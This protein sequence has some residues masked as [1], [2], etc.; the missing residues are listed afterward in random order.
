MIVAVLDYPHRRPPTRQGAR[1][2]ATVASAVSAPEARK[3]VAAPPPAP[4]PKVPTAE[5]V[6][7]Y[8]E[9]SMTWAELV[10]PDRVYG[11]PLTDMT[12][13]GYTVNEAWLERAGHPSQAVHPNERQRRALRRLLAINRILDI[14]NGVNRSE[15][16]R[17]GVSVPTNEQLLA[18]F[19]NPSQSPDPFWR[20]L[21]TGQNEKWHI[22][23]KLVDLL[24]AN[25]GRILQHAQAADRYKA[26]GGTFQGYSGSLAGYAESFSQG[27][28]RSDD[29]RRD[30]FGACV[31]ESALY[32]T[33]INEPT[34]GESRGVQPGLSNPIAD[35]PPRGSFQRSSV[36]QD[37][38]T[39]Q[40]YADPGYTPPRGSL[41]TADPRTG[42]RGS[43]QPFD[44][45]EDPRGSWQPFDPGA[46]PRGSLQTADPRTGPTGSLQTA[47]PASGSTSFQTSST[48]S[49][50]QG[51]A[52]T[53]AMT[54]A[55]ATHYATPTSSNVSG[56]GGELGFSL[57][58][59]TRPIERIVKDPF[60]IPKKV[61][62]P[63]EFR[64]GPETGLK[65]LSDF[66]DRAAGWAELVGPIASA[67]PHPY[68]QAGGATA[69][70][71]ADIY[72]S[73][74]D[75]QGTAQ[76]DF[77]DLLRRFGSQ[78]IQ[79][80]G[81][82]DLPP[83]APPPPP[84]PPPASSGANMAPLLIGAGALVAGMLLMGNKR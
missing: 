33:Q 17:L 60:L 67:I 46:D 19:N 83:A 76:T 18:D 25:K 38:Y 45:G 15:L 82:I 73:F 11:L 14:A 7:Q 39:L 8:P 26:K 55:A 51:A 47:D 48:T 22:Y 59:I 79:P 42:P 84:A 3:P 2:P 35:P 81:P 64:K 34:E 78:P 70:T 28:G 69:S 50:N 21:G 75:G 61:L 23:K 74:T 49:H 77:L 72:K 10:A 63:L 54:A 40:Q 36:G 16:K 58:D 53:A 41:Q 5:Q 12:G 32:E 57:R 24:R 29:C 4:K 44:P 80:F 20:G 52:A 30:R 56:Y 65:N 66:A 43:W 1:L 71:V 68:A 27:L 62:D 31:A 13:G 37:K 6:A 9:A